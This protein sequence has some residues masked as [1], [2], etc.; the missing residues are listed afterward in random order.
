MF[1]NVEVRKIPK[2]DQLV[3]ILFNKKVSMCKVKESS[4]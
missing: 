2:F 4:S 1:E 3:G